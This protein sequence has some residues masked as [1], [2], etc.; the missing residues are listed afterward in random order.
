MTAER[1]LRLPPAAGEPLLELL[2]GLIAEL[3]HVG[4]PVSL[5]ESLDVMQIVQHVRWENRDMLKH[6][7]AATLVKT[8]SHR[9]A[10]ETVFDVYFSLRGSEFLISDGSEGDLGLL[11][12]G[13]PDV[14]SAD[15]DASGSDITGSE[16]GDAAD[17]DAADRLAAEH[18]VDM[19]YKALLDGDF[20]AL[21]VA[22][23]QA[24]RRYAGMEPGRPVSGSY[25]LYRTLRA[26]DLGGMLERLLAAGQYTAGTAPD[27]DV[28]AQRLRRDA[29]QHRIA[30]LEA[31]LEAEIRCR[32]VADRGV[33]ALAK[34][35]RK[36]LPESI[37]FMHASSADMARLHRAV[38][39]LTR[40]LAARL[41]RRR[42]H[43]RS[44]PLDFRATMRRSLS[45]GGVPVELRFRK[46]RPGKPDI[47]AVA[48]ISGSVAA[49]SRFTLHLLYALS[50]QFT[51][52]RSFV[53][54]DGLDEVTSL[55]ESA[56]D[57]SEAMNRVNAEADVVWMDG[58][59]DYG[60]ALGVLWDRCRDDIGPRTTVLILGD[61]RS[62]YHDAESWIMHAISRKAR[63]MYW[64]NP[65]PR[66][67]WDTGDSI[68]GEYAPACDG[69]FEVRN[70]RQ[71]G[72]FV[73]CLA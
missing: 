5:T 66:G 24:V 33:E 40:K 48:D 28:L 15:G 63:R 19:L 8:H 59:S 20:D 70:L 6:A 44:G 58:H 1:D 56:V 55:L 17:R 14:G 68:I 51:K 12:D 67:Y 62:N 31:L 3:R 52:V 72:A 11:G 4:I 18:L 27:A 61:A 25:Y 42:R 47:V 36:P 23:S 41:A 9:D 71:L 54:I 46:L 16:S 32:L 30:E 29:C 49:F 45:C 35:L 60:H 73:D 2:G 22:A 43:G 7:L 64:L 53:F 69:V 38:Y 21:R 10:F 50:G 65:E 37:D 13:E 39:P 57:I 34:T 26:L